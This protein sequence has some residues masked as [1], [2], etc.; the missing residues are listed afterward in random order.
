MR[1]NFSKIHGSGND[2]IVIDHRNKI[3]EK[4]PPH[5][6]QHL[7]KFHTGIGADGLLLL[8]HSEKADFR[9]RFFNSDGYEAEMC[10]NGSRCICY[11]AYKK[12]IVEKEFIFEA[13]DGNHKAS[14]ENESKVKV[15]V[16]W[17]QKIE[18]RTVPSDFNFPANVQFK[19]YLNTGVPHLVLQC[20]DIDRVDVEEIGNNLRF[21]QYYAPAGT[22]VNFVEVLKN[23]DELKLKV[24]T[25]ERGVDA[26]TL[27]CGS[28]VTASALSYFNPHLKA[29]YIK[30]NTPGGEL[31]VFITK[32]QDSIFLL[33][34]VKIVYEGNYLEEDIL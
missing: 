6:V 2:F 28:G 20:S 11:F 15:E 33:G 9:M 22:N 13:M 12:G 34:P 31:T 24:R 8:E 21:H 17:N 30:I 7:C 26:E 23:D 5:F 1:F 32:K 4:W 14:I 27:S 29:D 16:L 10:A 25:F 18:K 19:N 3:L